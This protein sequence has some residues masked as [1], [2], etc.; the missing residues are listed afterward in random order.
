MDGGE[1]GGEEGNRRLYKS[2]PPT[3]LLTLSRRMYAMQALDKR[4]TA[5]HFREHL[6]DVLDVHKADARLYA[7]RH[8]LLNIG[9]IRSGREDRLDP[10]AMRR[11]NLLLE[12][13]DREHLPHERDLARH[14]DVRADRRL[15]EQRDERGEQRRARAR[16]FF[17]DAALG[18][19]HVQV[20]V[21]QNHRRQ[22]LR[23]PKRVRVRLGPA[24]RDLGALAND[25]AQLSRQL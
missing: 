10:R 20:A 9:A 18:H 6:L 13:A 7:L 23:H 1:G 4:G 24:Q 14:G 21:V 19:V 12:S 25:F 22:V 2:T 3:R 8:V 15:G 11:Q 17:A 16:P 5:E